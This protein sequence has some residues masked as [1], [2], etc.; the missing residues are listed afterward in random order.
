ML[1]LWSVSII[2]NML[3]FT[4]PYFALVWMKIC[5]GLDENDEQIFNPDE[6]V[7]LWKVYTFDRFY[8]YILL[9][10]IYICFRL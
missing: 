2:V 6:N 1:N 4:S 8:F 5:P 10:W 9:W 3:S 7:N